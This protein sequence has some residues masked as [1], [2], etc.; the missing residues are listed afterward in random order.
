M[1]KIHSQKSSQM[2]YLYNGT[3]KFSKGV[4]RREN[5]RD[6]VRRITFHNK[7]FLKETRENSKIFY[8]SSLVLVWYAT[9]TPLSRVWWFT[10]L[11][12]CV[13]GPRSHGHLT[14][15]LVG[16]LKKNHICQDNPTQT[17]FPDL[18]D[19]RGSEVIFMSDTERLLP[20]L[21]PT[22]TRQNES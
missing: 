14:P 12:T 18:E 11:L 17:N 4:I 7:F 10:G 15:F 19:I 9:L 21:P 8:G 2:I 6:R 20:S 22:Y 16:I 3:V 13:C 1:S 5:S